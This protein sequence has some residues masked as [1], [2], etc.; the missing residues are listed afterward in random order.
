MNAIQT[1][2]KHDSLTKQVKGIFSNKPLNIYAYK[3]RKKNI[4]MT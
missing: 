1:K 2:E 4:I 3:D